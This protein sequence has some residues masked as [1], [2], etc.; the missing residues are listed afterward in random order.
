VLGERGALVPIPAQDAGMEGAE[1]LQHGAAHRVEH[2]I[3]SH[4]GNGGVEGHVG[5]DGLLRAALQAA[6]LAGQGGLEPCNVLVGGA[7]RGFR[8]HAGLEEFPRFLELLEGLRRGGEQ[9]TRGAIDLSDD[10]EGGGLDH[11][12]PLDMGDDEETELLERLHRLADGGTADAIGRHQ[13]AL[14]GDLAAR[15]VLAALDRLQQTIEDLVRQF[16]PD[17]FLGLDDRVRPQVAHLPGAGHRTWIS[18]FR[19]NAPG[20]RLIRDNGSSP[21]RRDRGAAGRRLIGPEHQRIGPQVVRARS[22]RHAAGG[23]RVDEMPLGLVD[24]ILQGMPGP[25]FLIGLIVPVQMTLVPLTV[26]YR[27]LGLIDS[28]PGLF[29]LYL[30]FGLPFGVLV[31][32]GFFRTLPRELIEAA[33]LDGCSWLG[34][35]WRVV[36]PLSK[37]ALVS[38]L[39]LDG[40]ATWN[41][42]VLAQIFLR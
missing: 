37:P 14:G 16:S 6:L 20:L 22:L 4:R 19:R 27:Q 34:V 8:G 42:F 12:R 13:L 29:F 24:A 41:E 3:P 18:A 9:V 35:F 36:L 7:A 39:I 21:H 33:L 1:P 32:R 40:I 10:V 30:G 38:L 17:D 25:L 26:L 15:L 11:P 23:E 5:G 2:G 31:L 28:L